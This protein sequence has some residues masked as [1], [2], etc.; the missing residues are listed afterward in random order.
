[1]QKSGETSFAGRSSGRVSLRPGENGIAY[2]SVS[3]AIADGMAADY[4]LTLIAKLC[5]SG[6]V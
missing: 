3:T 5:Q 2:L 4:R 1:M 6:Q